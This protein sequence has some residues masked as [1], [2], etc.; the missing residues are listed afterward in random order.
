MTAW[1]SDELSKIAAAEE[2][3]IAP[4]RP[5]GTLRKPVPI[6]VVRHGD[7]L[8]VRSYK[9]QNGAWFRDAQR[10][11]QGRIRAD[12]V[13]KDVTFAEADH[14]LDDQIDAAYRAKYQP[15]AAT[16]VPPML[17]PQARATTLRLVPRA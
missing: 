17:T 5:D 1:P 16:F 12:G 3:D 2:L 9:G 14:A 4:L 11:H 6:W 7:D 8:Y 15:Y 10:T 13:Q